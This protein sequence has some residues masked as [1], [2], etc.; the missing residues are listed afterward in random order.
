MWQPKRV[1]SNKKTVWDGK[2]SVWLQ[3]WDLKTYDGNWEDA[4]SDLQ[5]YW[6]QWEN[7]SWNAILDVY[8]SNT[9][10]PIWT[11][12]DWIKAT[13]TFKDYDG[14]VLKTGTVDDGETPVAPAD[15]TRAATAQYT[16]TFAGW[17]P[18]VW[19]IAKNTVYTATYTSTV[20][21]YTVTIATNDATYGTVSPASVTAPYGASISASDNVLT[22]WETTVTATAESGYVFSSWGTLPETVTWATTITATFEQQLY[23]EINEGLSDTTGT[24]G[25]QVSVYFSTVW[26]PWVLYSDDP[27]ILTVADTDTT[28]W[29]WWTNKVTY[30]VG[31]TWTTTA[32]ITVTKN[33]QTVSDSIQITCSAATPSVPTLLNS[34]MYNYDDEVGT[35]FENNGSYVQFE[36]TQPASLTLDF[37]GDVNNARVKQMFGVWE[38]SM[39]LQRSVMGSINNIDDAASNE[40]SDAWGSYNYQFTSN[41][42][43]AIETFLASDGWDEAIVALSMAIATEASANGNSILTIIP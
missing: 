34:V 24:V 33:G 9:P 12:E 23:I 10:E 26:N 21:T 5:T 30:N 17:S 20:N 8:D 22:I 40:Y 13:Y 36:W 3:D 7:V 32:T 1:W 4:G 25:W 43:T 6:N 2:K 31:G 19:P 37:I 27:D 41:A 29:E 16:Y 38:P 15:P 39:N 14:T 42:W 28:G 11:A 35:V 18:T